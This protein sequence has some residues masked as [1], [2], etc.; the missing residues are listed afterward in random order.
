VVVQG[1]ETGT[2]ARI[3]PGMTRVGSAPGNHV[4]LTDPTVSRFH[5]EL[6]LA[7]GA[8]R[9]VDL[10]STNGTY[11][12]GVRVRDALLPPGGTIAFGGTV[13]RV[14]AGAPVD[15]ELSPVSRFG[16]VLGSSLEMRRLFRILDRAAETDATVLLRGE[17]G[18]GKEIVAQSLHEASRRASG[19]FV[20]VD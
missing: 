17:T 8:L 10:E 6:H 2:R 15:V 16:S 7:G 18:T 4:R 3:E 5:C 9:V 13:V 20:A 14:H 12:N 19:P 11:V 1:P